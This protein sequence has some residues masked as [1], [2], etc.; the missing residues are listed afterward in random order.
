MKYI[1]SKKI[2]DFVT[3][4][5]T[6]KGYKRDVGLIL[7][8]LFE[9]VGELSGAI[10]RYETEQEHHADC[11]LPKREQVAMELVD[12]ISLANYIADVLKIDLNNAFPKR[13]I[14]VARQY[15]VKKL[16]K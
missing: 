9:E 6:K 13:M 4:V 10:Y 14:Q 11:C 5:E 2:Q 15:G 1:N 16:S 12:I 7:R 3:L 8:H